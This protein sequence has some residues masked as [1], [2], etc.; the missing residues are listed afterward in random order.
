MAG[1]TWVKHNMLVKVRGG[2]EILRVTDWY[3]RGHTRRESG[4][5]VPNT[6]VCEVRLNDGTTMPDHNL[7]RASR[8][9]IMDAGYPGA[10]ISKR[11]EGPHPAY[12]AHDPNKPP[13]S[14]MMQLVRALSRKRA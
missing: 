7:E 3:F 8:K 12:L 4:W 2:K 5:S 10:Y 1:T 11:A 14:S 9:D 13:I 6:D